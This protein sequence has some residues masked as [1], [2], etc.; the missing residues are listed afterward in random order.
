MKM[1]T[2]EFLDLCRKAGVIIGYDISFGYH[3][4]QKIAW[5]ADFEVVKKIE[6][7]AKKQIFGFTRDFEGYYYYANLEE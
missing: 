1:K 5:T 4:N 7:I 6:K 2:N 3:A